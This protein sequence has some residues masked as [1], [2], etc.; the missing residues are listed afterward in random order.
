MKSLDTHAPPSQGERFAGAP[1]PTAR[2]LPLSR[3]LS[4]SSTLFL[5]LSERPQPPAQSRSLAE[6]A[7][8]PP[9][10]RT[11]GPGAAP[12]PPAPVA[13]SPAGSPEPEGT[14]PSRRRALTCRSP[15]T[16]W[17]L[18][19]SSPPFPRSLGPLPS[20][21]SRG[22]GTA[23]AAPGPLARLLSSCPERRG[24]SGARRRR[25]WARRQDA[26][27]GSGR[28]AEGAGCERALSGPRPG[29]EL[30]ARGRGKKWG[31]RARPTP[32]CRGPRGS[33]GFLGVP[34]SG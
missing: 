21:P 33:S 18:A 22:L 14:D 20:S 2:A 19:P 1:F 23:P 26:E 3:C 34:V 9:S 11:P 13:S 28:G 32:P 24:A 25:G 8:A 5:R 16:G 27:V 30:Q 10:H 29:W 31:P 6:G 17:P 4:P 15:P 7:L 12:E